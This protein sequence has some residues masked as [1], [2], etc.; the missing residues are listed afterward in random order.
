MTLEEFMFSTNGNDAKQSLVSE[1]TCELMTKDS[2][3]R[4]LEYFY[5]WHEKSWTLRKLVLVENKSGSLVMNLYGVGGLDG[6]IAGQL[7]FI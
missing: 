7:Y 2:F 6:H 1:R 5:H 4:C 3:A